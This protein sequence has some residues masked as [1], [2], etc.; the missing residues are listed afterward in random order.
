MDFVTVQED[1]LIGAVCILTKIQITIAK[2]AGKT[3]DL[4]LNLQ[5]EALIMCTGEALIMSPDQ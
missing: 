3:I 5:G 1:Y 2:G 4:P